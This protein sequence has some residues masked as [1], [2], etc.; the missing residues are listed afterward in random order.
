MF[1]YNNSKVSNSYRVFLLEVIVSIFF[2]AIFATVATKVF[3]GAYENNKSS[4][5]LNNAIIYSQD[6]METFTANN[7]DINK[8]IKDFGFD[9]SENNY[10]ILLDDNLNKTSNNYTYKVL[11]NFTPN[12]TDAGN[13]INANIKILSNKEKEI[14]SLSNDLYISNTH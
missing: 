5:E 2:F 7:G 10:L 13:L 3:V 6:F 4:I 12:K 1:N 14:Y 8:T 11:I 9:G